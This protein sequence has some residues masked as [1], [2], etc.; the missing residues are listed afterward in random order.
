MYASELQRR[1]SSQGSP[2][3]VISLNPTTVNTFS[4][5]PLLK[6]IS[7]FTPPATIPTLERTHPPLQPPH[8][9]LC[10]TRI[11]SRVYIWS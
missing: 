8:P 3:T 1:L 11:S 2:I 10:K 5:N 7:W 9:R 6:R 4:R